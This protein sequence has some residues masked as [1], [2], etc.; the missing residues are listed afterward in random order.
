[1]LGDGFRSWGDVVYRCTY[2]SDSDWEEFMRRF[3]FHVRRTLEDYDGLNMLD[4]FMP[5]TVIDDKPRFDG[6]TPAIVRD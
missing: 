6:V 3:L 4:S 1:M 2:K 5:T